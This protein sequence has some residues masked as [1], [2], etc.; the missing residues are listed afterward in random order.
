M[1]DNTSANAVINGH[2]QVIAVL[3]VG[4]IL[5]TWT[6][7]FHLRRKMVLI[8]SCLVACNRLALEIL[9]GQKPRMI[10]LRQVLWKIA[11]QAHLAALFHPMK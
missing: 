5:R 3:A 4:S 2:C 6:S 8:A 1:T 7:H 10:L 11:H 9:L